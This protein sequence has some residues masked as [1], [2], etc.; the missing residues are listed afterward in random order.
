M[1][2]VT[3]SFLS[4]GLLSQLSNFYEKYSLLKKVAGGSLETGMC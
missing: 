1:N 4:V 2:E 3:V